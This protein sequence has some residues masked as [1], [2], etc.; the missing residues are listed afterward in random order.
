MKFYGMCQSD[1]WGTPPELWSHLNDEF[2]FTFDPCPF[3]GEQGLEMRWG[4]CNFVNPPYSKAKEFAMKCREEQ[5]LGNT[6]VLL[7]PAHTSAAYFHEWVL[8]YAEL[9]FVKGR[10]KFI[11]LLEP[12]KKTEAAPFSSVVCIFRPRDE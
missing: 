4:K 9:R 8:P 3:A 12:E 2:N 10:L 1:E 11:N 5:T 6:S 7:I